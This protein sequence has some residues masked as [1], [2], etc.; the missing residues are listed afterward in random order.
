MRSKKLR[1][2]RFGDDLGVLIP[3]EI[4]TSWGVGEG[5][6]LLLSGSSIRPPRYGGLPHA[7]LDDMNRAIALAVVRSFT[8]SE[9][10][11]KILSNLARW[12]EQGT[13]VTAYDEW[14]SIAA[15][16]DDGALFAAML[17]RDEESTRLRQS[18]PFVG[19]LSQEEVRALHEEASS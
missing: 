17:G 9:I 11:E 4:L 16:S 15:R 14:R 10:R 3:E 1:V 2:Q 7:K 6:D 12:E 13:W 19:L 18:P 5:E 8:P